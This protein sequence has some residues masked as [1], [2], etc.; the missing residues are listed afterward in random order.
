MAETVEEL[1]LPIECKDGLIYANRQLI[2]NISKYYQNLKKEYL[3]VEILNVPNFTKN[4]ILCF[5]KLI[6]KN[7]II[8]N[9][10][11]TIDTK[12]LIQLIDYFDLKERKY[13]LDLICQFDDELKSIIK[14]PPFLMDETFSY[15]DNELRH[16]KWI[17]EKAIH[18]A[19]DYYNNS[20]NLLN[21]LNCN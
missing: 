14:F 8:I 12:T 4:Q 11:L 9:E 6:D 7:N 13:V 3:T 18:D 19:Q 1:I 5:L 21:A 16:L 10:D 2:S 20:Y 17:Q 15:Q